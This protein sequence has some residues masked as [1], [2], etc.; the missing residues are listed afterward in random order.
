[1]IIVIPIKGTR[2]TIK[3]RTR[4]RIK[5]IKGRTRDRTRDRTSG[6]INGT[7]VTTREGIGVTKSNLIVINKDIER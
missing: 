2:G 1:V 6:A 7:K 5:V 3:G 4:D